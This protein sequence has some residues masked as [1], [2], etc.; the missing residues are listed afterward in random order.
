M[1]QYRQPVFARIPGACAD[2]RARLFDQGLHWL[3][4]CKL[5]GNKFGVGMSSVHSNIVL[6][7]G[8]IDGNL[9]LNDLN[10][11]SGDM[12]KNSSDLNQLARNTLKEIAIYRSLNRRDL[13]RQTKQNCAEI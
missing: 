6:V 13:I 3:L 5:V 7:S 11:L 1:S 4:Q 9:E 8:A 2:A 12:F 10:R